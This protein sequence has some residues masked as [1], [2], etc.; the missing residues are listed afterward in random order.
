[1]SRPREALGLN[2]DRGLGMGTPALAI[3][4]QRSATPA[5]RPPP[6]ETG[7]NGSGESWRLLAVV[8]ASRHPGR[9]KLAEGRAS[10]DLRWFLEAWTD[11]ASHGATMTKA[12]EPSR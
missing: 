1:M 11:Q 12:F 6:P 2:G 7:W 4:R 8:H 10:W 9:S 3:T 5:D